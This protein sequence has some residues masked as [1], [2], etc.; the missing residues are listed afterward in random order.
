MCPEADPSDTEANEL[1][2]PG[3]SSVGIF[4]AANTRRGVTHR[5]CSNAWLYALRLIP[6]GLPGYTYKRYDAP[7]SFTI[8]AY[9]PIQ[10]SI[11]GTFS[12]GRRTCRKVYPTEH[13]IPPCLP[14]TRSQSLPH[15]EGQKG[16]CQ[17]L[18]SQ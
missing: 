1:K 8:Y 11:T 17:P 6:D 18:P 5:V 9:C 4:I 7:N 12:P 3:H 13:S 10:S 2:T 16:H 14:T 15:R